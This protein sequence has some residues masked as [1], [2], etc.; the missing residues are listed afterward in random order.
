M[1][2]ILSVVLLLVVVPILR[3]QDVVLDT[4]LVLSLLLFFLLFTQPMSRWHGTGFLLTPVSDHLL[5]HLTV[6]FCRIE[7]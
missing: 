5:I 1:E 4:I 2:T 3:L 6:D 7:A